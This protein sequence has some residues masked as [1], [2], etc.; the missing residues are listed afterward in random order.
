MEKKKL[1]GM[2]L[3][4]LLRLGQ[5]MDQQQAENFLARVMELSTAATEAAQS[6]A[7]AMEFLKQQA[8]NKGDTRSRFSDA[9]KVLK[10]PECFD[11]DDPIKF[12]MWREQF[13][14][15]LC[16]SDSRYGELVKLAE[17]DFSEETAELSQRL[18]S[19]LASYLKGPAAQIVRS[20]QN[21]RNGFGLWQRLKRFMLRRHGREP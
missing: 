14:N 20:F 12:T 8:E 11:V 7:S 5:A 21:K 17:N 16:F 13:L 3:V 9:S 6:T 4:F 1:R 18:Y 19:I 15:W 2:L 10:Q